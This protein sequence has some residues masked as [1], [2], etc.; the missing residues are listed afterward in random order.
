MNV[1]TMSAPQLH[2]AGKNNR[3][4]LVNVTQVSVDGEDHAVQMRAK[5]TPSNPSNKDVLDLTT[6][7]SLATR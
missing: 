2:G 3:T 1:S 6:P 4:P 5:R 7:K